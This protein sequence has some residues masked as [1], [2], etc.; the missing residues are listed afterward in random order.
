LGIADSLAP[1]ISILEAGWCAAQQI[2]GPQYRITINGSKDLFI[3]L[4]NS[5]G[6]VKA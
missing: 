2:L 4:E 6:A 1:F 3:C 5:G